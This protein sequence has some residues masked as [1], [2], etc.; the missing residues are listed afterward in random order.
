MSA[1]NHREERQTAVNPK[2]DERPKPWIEWPRLERDGRKELL[3][4][5]EATARPDTDFC[6][7]MLLSVALAALGLLQ[8]SVAVVIG[9]M[10]VAPLMGPLVGAGLALTQG[11][12]RLFRTSL[13]TVAIG[14]TIGL[15][16]SL[17]LGL[18]NPGFEPSMEIEARGNPDILDLG[19]AFIAGM[20]AGWAMGRPNVAGSLAGVAIAAALVPPLAVVGIAFTNDQAAIGTNASILVTT[21][22]V[23]IVLGAAL[24]FRML[25]AH[26]ALGERETPGWARLASFALMAASLLLVMPLVSGVIKARKIGQ[27]RPLAHPVAARTRAA[28]HDFLEAWP[29][30]R[31]VVISRDSIEPHG[32]VS[33]MLESPTPVTPD[34]DRKL[35][36]VIR[37]SRGEEVPVQV[38]AFRSAWSSQ[39]EGWESQDAETPNRMLRG[40]PGARQRDGDP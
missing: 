2:D 11:N 1:K 30:Y 4:R 35:K 18:M 36:Q 5:V 14:L 8:G 10:L 39:P 17:L 27:D 7:M 21:N 29:E 25:R 28:V 20:A 23:A 38:F 15:G 37:A 40:H 19:I 6:L 24:A 12:L 16:V 26:A 34:F 3:E 9:A 32:T 31:L 33:A 13:V 22:V